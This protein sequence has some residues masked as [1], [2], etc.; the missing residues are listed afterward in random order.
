MRVKRKRY[1][2]KS[3]YTLKLF[4]DFYTLISLDFYAGRRGVSIN[5]SNKAERI[6]VLTEKVID[7]VYTHVREALETSCR[8]EVRHAI[9]ESYARSEVEAWAKK[10]ETDNLTCFHIN[11]PSALT[12]DQIYNVFSMDG[13]STQ[14]GGKSW[15]IAT[16]FLFENPSTYLG[17]VAWIDRVFDHEHNNGNI[18]DKTDFGILSEERDIKTALTSDNTYL[19][20]W[21][22]PLD[23]RFEA[24]LLD[25]AANASSG[26]YK[27]VMANLNKVPENALR[28]PEFG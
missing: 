11:A 18:L 15:A 12:I 16:K 7:E 9:S 20:K 5:H 10:W 27:L 28:C 1:F 14:Y 22:T 17:K 6:T 25:L 23:F 21:I 2:E 19:A 24:R 3:E 13:W 4:F 26:T 8:Q